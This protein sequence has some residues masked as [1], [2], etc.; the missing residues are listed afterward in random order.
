MSRQRLDTLNS[1][2]QEHSLR[3]VSRSVRQDIVAHPELQG[4]VSEIS[5]LV[6]NPNATA[7]SPELRPSFTCTPSIDLEQGLPK[8]PSA[9]E[10]EP[11]QRTV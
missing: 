7:W 4:S 11:G 10:Q 5:F 3:R 8:L 6:S 1:K 2:L 9:V